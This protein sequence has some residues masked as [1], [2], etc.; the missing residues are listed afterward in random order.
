MAARTSNVPFSNRWITAV[1]LW[2]V[3]RSWVTILA[4]S[5]NMSAISGFD[6]HLQVAS[7]DLSALLDTAQG[8]RPPRVGRRHVRRR[9]RCACVLRRQLT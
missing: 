6:A 8:R 2:K 5:L 1:L 3:W 7:V 4:S 9:W